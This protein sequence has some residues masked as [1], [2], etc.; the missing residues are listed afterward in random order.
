MATTGVQMASNKVNKVYASPV[1]AFQALPTS[2][3]AAKLVQP[4]KVEFYPQD[5]MVEIDLKGHTVEELAAA[6][7]VSVDVIQDAIN[8]RKQQILFEKRYASYAH[9]ILKTSTT[10][11]TTQ[12]T[13]S[14]PPTERPTTQSPTTSTTPFIPKKKVITKK[15][16]SNG[17]KVRHLS[18]S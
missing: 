11:R 9:Q 18:R 17:H 15:P 13:T 7:H 10:I 6:A 14:S 1:P 16:T 8:L 4:T 2:I 5:D 12:S 3:T